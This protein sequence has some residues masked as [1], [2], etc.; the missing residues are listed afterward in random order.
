MIVIFIAGIDA[1]V[2]LTG[3]AENQNGHVNRVDE[4]VNRHKWG[5]SACY[6]R[7]RAH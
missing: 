6:K 5:V 2:E 7:V 4:S 3:Q 1:R